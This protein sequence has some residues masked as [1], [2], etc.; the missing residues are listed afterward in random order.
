VLE[1]G[2]EHWPFPVPI[3]QKDGRWFFDTEA[4]AE[5]ILSRRIGQN[6]LA[7]LEVVRAYVDAPA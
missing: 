5:E 3:V 7:V 4:G 1:V 2:E 6:E